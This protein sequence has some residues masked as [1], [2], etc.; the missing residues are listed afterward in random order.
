MQTTRTMALTKNSKIDYSVPTLVKWAGGKK[1]LLP[2]FE[3]FFPEKIERYIEPFVGGGAVAFHIIKQF[4][5]KFVLLSDI[6][7]ELINAYNITKSN[8]FELIE[9]LDLLAKKHSKEFYYEI[10]SIDP[11][12]L[13]K[14]DM[15]AR[16]IYLNKTCFNGLY[17]VNSNGKFNVPIGSY[18]DPRILDRQSLL[19]ISDLLKNAVIKVMPFDGVLDFARSGD[20]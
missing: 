13:S 16:F 10:R 9:A 14:I 5:P 17:R 20:F 15:A 1:Q 19:E 7:E 3:S 6:N 2:Q 11:K 8:V 4:K 18:K 12:T